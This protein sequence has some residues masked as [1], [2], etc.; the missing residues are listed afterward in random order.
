MGLI[1]KENIAEDCL[2]GI[3][4][5]RESYDQ[6]FARVNLSE[7]E[8]VKLNSFQNERRK[9]EWL[10]VRALIKAV[11]ELDVRIVYNESRK[12]FLEDRTFNISISHSRDLTAVLLSRNNRVGID[13]EYMSHDIERLAHKFVNERE[14]ITDDENRHNFHLYIHWC[15]KEALYKICD[16]QDI[17]FKQNLTLKPFDAHDEGIITG[18]VNNRFGL[19]DYQLH[20][21]KYDNYIIAWCMK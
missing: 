4:E 20:Y 19:E 7:E 12:P 10:S 2:L 15:A 9:L 17:N 21:Y 13:L 14:F 16:K 3:W 5:I 1:M 8:L 18:V 6:L 11:L